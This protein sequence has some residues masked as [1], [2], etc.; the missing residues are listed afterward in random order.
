M[1]K[2]KRNPY[3]YQNPNHIRNY[4][5]PS[6]GVD[7]GTISYRTYPDMF[8]TYQN[9]SELMNISSNQFI[10]A[11]GGENAI[12]NCLLAIKPKLLI[13]TVPG[14]GMIPVY[15]DALEIE[16]YRNPII[17]TGERYF[18]NKVKVPFYKKSKTCYYDYYG[19]TN[20][21]SYNNNELETLNK[22]IVI[23]DMTYRKIQEVKELYRSII[24]NPNRI[25]VGS[26]DKQYGAGIRLGYV[27][28]NPIWNDRMQIQRE[29]FINPSACK[30]LKR[31]VNGKYKENNTGKKNLEFLLSLLYYRRLKVITKTENFVTVEGHLDCSQM[32]LVHFNIGDK[33]FTRFPIPT[34]N[35][36]KLFE[37]LIK[38][39]M[40]SK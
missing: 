27:L 22:E 30:F 29:Q 12:K 32:N 10:L 20:F 35:E 26:F 6:C 23:Y 1:N 38:Y 21:I 11:N 8:N 37:T 31:L 3:I 33:T 14:W 9:F 24:A 34:C 7:I 13:D 25:I 36:H 39:V 5:E 2:I 40:V 16:N 4:N 28:F 15:C 19:I 17:N 18:I